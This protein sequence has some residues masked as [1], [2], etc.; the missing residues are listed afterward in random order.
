MLQ[1]YVEKKYYDLH[2]IRCVKQ[3]YWCKYKHLAV[4]CGAY[5]MPKSAQI[6][7]FA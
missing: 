2:I 1:K 6:V 4:L 7:I 3:K 5:Q